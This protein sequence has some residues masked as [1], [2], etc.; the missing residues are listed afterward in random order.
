LKSKSYEALHCIISSISLL[1]HR[2]QAQKSSTRPHSRKP[3][4]YVLHTV[5]HT[6]FRNYMIQQTQ[7]YFL[8]V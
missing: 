5:R 6:K 7:L 1:T 8:T 3:S 4:A 2:S